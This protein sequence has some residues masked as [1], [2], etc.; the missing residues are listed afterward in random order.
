MFGFSLQAVVSFFV[1][2]AALPLAHYLRPM[3]MLFLILLVPALVIMGVILLVQVFEFAELYWPGSL[4]NQVT[5]QPL[6]QRCAGTLGQHSPG[7]LQ[8]TAGDG[9]RHHRQPAGARLAGI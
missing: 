7:L 9:H 8:R 6:A 2:L 5:L 1:L 3:D 4:Q